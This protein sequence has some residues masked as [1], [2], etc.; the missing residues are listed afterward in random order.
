MITATATQNFHLE[1]INA[2]D[3]SY[4][5]PFD[6]AP[7]KKVSAVRTDNG[8]CVMYVCGGYTP[9]SGKASREIHVFYANGDMWY[10]FGTSVA[11]AVQGA[12]ADMWKQGI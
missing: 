8:T 4:T 11:S 1:P 2:T 9:E 10:S 12:F 6:C 3:G 5:L 7:Y